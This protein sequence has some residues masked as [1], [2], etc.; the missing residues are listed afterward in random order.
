MQC[1]K[2]FCVHIYR[3][4]KHYSSHQYHQSSTNA[5]CASGQVLQT[6]SVEDTRRQHELLLLAFKLKEF[7][8]TDEALEDTLKVI[9]VIS[10]RHAVSSTKY[11]FY[12]K[13]DD[14]KKPI[15]FHYM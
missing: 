2:H 7:G 8:L 5:S 6:A 10:E 15:Q 1:F 4:V 9:N 12:K 14:L 11:L 13:F 3:S